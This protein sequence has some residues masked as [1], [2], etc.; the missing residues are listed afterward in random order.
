M[1]TTQLLEYMKSDKL[2]ELKTDENY[3][4]LATITLINRYSA[5]GDSESAAALIQE[6]AATGTNVGRL[7]R[8]FAELKTSSP[9]SMSQVVLGMAE[10]RG[11]TVDEK[12]KKYVN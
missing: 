1:T 9:E 4:P 11:K 2:G 6:L 12:T 10:A 3:G 7:L 8:Q 5:A